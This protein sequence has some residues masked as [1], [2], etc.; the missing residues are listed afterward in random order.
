MLLLF[1]IQYLY[2]VYLVKNWGFTAL[3]GNFTKS[4]L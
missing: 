2:F 3:Q 4:E 1:Y